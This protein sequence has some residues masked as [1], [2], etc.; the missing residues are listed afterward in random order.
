MITVVTG[1]PRSGTSLMMQMLEAGGMPVLKDDLR[2]P[3]ADNPNG[4]YEYEPVRRTAANVD[5]VSEADGKAV[6]VIYALLRHLPD[7][8][9]YR[10]I[11]MRRDMQ[12][13][14]A[15]QQAMLERRGAQGASVGTT[16]LAALFSVDLER[17]LAELRARPGLR[18]LQIEHRA[19]LETPADVASQI[20]AFL[21]GVLDPARMAAVPKV[22]LY[23]RRATGTAGG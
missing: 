1:L 22:S 13:V 3:D 4:Y 8:P 14:L 23:R 18:L 19:C 20:S 10:V 5:W 7:G 11:A 9:E 15:S 21:G 12:E 2:A 6:K 17:A 16:E